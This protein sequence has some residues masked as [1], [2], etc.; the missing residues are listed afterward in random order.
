MKKQIAVRNQEG[1]QLHVQE[2]LPPGGVVHGFALLAHC[3]TC[4]SNFAAVRN[5]GRELTSIGFG[6]VR[7]DFTGLGK[8]EG[9]LDDSRFSV[10]VDDLKSVYAHMEAQGKAPA[11]LIG[12]SLGGAAVLMAAGSLPGVKAVVTVGAPSEAVHVK[13]H[14]ESALDD[15]HEHGSAE[16]NLG[17]RPFRISK[18]FVDDLKKH[19]VLDAVKELRK[20]L[21]VAHSPQDRVVGIANAGEIYTA[22][23][24]PKSFVS[25]DGS[26]HML[27]DRAD[28]QYLANLI[29]AWASRYIDADIKLSSGG[30]S[31]S[32]SPV[33]DTQGEQVLA[34][35]DFSDGF[36]T[37][38]SNGRVTVLADEPVEVGGDGLGLSPYELLNAA[39]GACTAMTL[40]LYATRKDWP[41]EE[42]SVFLSHERKHAEDMGDTTKP[43][44]IDHLT[45]RIRFT[46]SLDEEQRQRLL[47]IAAKCPVHQTL[48]GEI[49]I[50]TEEEERG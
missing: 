43:K 18:A 28:S 10:N 11:L 3:F 37:Q 44:R 32:P 7:F 47:E 31:D 46:G 27:T 29:A 26:D 48:L 42:V 22:A 9:E 24:H 50:E 13:Q 5:I 4:N 34:R 8:S 33:L 39:L 35:L 38:I 20:P 12:H 17:G 14:F 30:E 45:K 36:T 40:K 1:F 2:E 6:V 19:A 25:L 41:L 23:F 21:L 49:R 15:I 16:V